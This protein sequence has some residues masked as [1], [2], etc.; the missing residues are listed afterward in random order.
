MIT[1]AAVSIFVGVFSATDIFAG[2]RSVFV[3]GR[4]VN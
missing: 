1:S 4:S 3:I 2:T